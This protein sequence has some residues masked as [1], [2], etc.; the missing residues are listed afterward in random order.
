[1]ASMLIDLVAALRQEYGDEFPVGEQSLT[2]DQLVRAIMRSVIFLNRD[3]GT[4]YQVVN[5][6]I[7]PTLEDDD[8]EL[9]LLRAM[10]SVAEKM[11]AIY[12]RGASIKSGDKSV[13]H[14]DQVDAWSRLHKQF[15]QQYQSAVNRSMDSY[16]D[17]IDPML[18]G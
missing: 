5:D 8:L 2:A 4:S 14:S 3:F 11:L 1:M 16:L 13:S 17:E 7:T 9:L 18:Y 12:T 6:E 15:L 10:V